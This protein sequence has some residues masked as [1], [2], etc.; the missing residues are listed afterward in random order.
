MQ[1][2]Q[3]VSEGGYPIWYVAGSTK[4]EYSGTPEVN[5]RFEYLPV[6]SGLDDKKRSV[7]LF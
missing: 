3:E 6:K 5:L 2:C 4:I 7:H 1:V